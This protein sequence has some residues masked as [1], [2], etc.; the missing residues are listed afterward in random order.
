MS[1]PVDSAEG[2]CAIA[3]E[4][5]LALCGVGRIGR[6]SPVLTPDA[7]ASAWEKVAYHNHGDPWCEERYWVD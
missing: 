7:A 1:K 6:Y 3:L 2:L 5:G 4:R